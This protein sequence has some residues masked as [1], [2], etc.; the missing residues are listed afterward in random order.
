M[1]KGKT[2]KRGEKETKKKE[3]KTRGN[4]V[5]SERWVVNNRGKGKIKKGKNGITE[6]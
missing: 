5:Q 4:I 1:T 6:T 3:I 2:I